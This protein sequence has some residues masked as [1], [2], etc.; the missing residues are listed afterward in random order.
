[1]SLLVDK[2]VLQSQYSRN[3]LNIHFKLVSL[4]VS[5]L[6]SLATTAALIAGLSFGCIH[7]FDYPTKYLPTEWRF[8][9]FYT[10]VSMLALIFSILSLS[11]TTICL[12]FGPTMFLFGESHS[13]S[14]S[15][16]NLMRHQQ[17]EGFF[18]SCSSVAM[19]YLQAL[20]F[21]WGVAHLPVACIV[22]VTHLIGYYIIYTQGMKT[23]N[24]L[25]PK[26][27]SSG[28]GGGGGGGGDNNSQLTLKNIVKNSILGLKKTDPDHP[29][30][31][32]NLSL[33][34][35]NF[36]KVED[37]KAVLNPYPSLR[38]DSCSIFFKFVVVDIFGQ[39]MRIKVINQIILSEC[40]WF[41]TKVKSY[42]IGRKRSC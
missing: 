31:L 6:N 4:Y 13:D 36:S 24:E 9:Y 1:M 12:I 40:M 27:S 21:V 10:L 41:L 19:A 5:N 34:A 15:A 3:N 18:W 17:R 39:K 22:T 28:A 8:G 11:Q 35:N 14:L 38:N 37:I 7:E 16:L 42:F 30:V 20:F 2:K 29:L 32:A 33:Q 23:M 26:Q 25:L